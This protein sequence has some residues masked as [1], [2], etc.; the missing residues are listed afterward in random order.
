MSSVQLNA[1]MIYKVLKMTAMYQTFMIVFVP[2]FIARASGSQISPDGDDGE[3]AC[4]G[5]QRTLWGIIWSCMATIFACTWLAVHPNVPGRYVTTKGSISCFIENAKTMVLAVFAPEMIVGWAAG[6]FTMAWKLHRGRYKTITSVID[7]A[8]EQEVQIKL[9]LA[10]GFLVCMGG[11]Y[12]TRKYEIPD[13]ALDANEAVSTPRLSSPPSS[14]HDIPSD[15]TSPSISKFIPDST[16]PWETLDLPGT[17]VTIDVLESEPDLVKKLAAIDP[18]TI[19]DRSKGDTLSKTIS[20]LQLSWF[21]VQCVARTNQHL[22]ITLLEMSALSFAGLSMITYSLWWYKPL[23]VKY[24]ISLDEVDVAPT[25]RTYNSKEFL[26]LVMPF[27]H[28]ECTLQDECY[29]NILDGVCGGHSGTQI[30]SGVRLGTTYGVGLLFGAFHCLAWSFYFPSYVEMVLWRFS[31]IAVIIAVFMISYPLL[32]ATIC[33]SV[34]Q[35]WTPEREETKLFMFS[36]FR[37]GFGRVILLIL[38]FLELRALSPLAFC[39]VQWTTYIPH[40]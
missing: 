8:T 4:T 22:P 34:D 18:E 3:P 29:S 33:S 9:T 5:D 27:L 21:I 11:F 6:Q 32:I 38:A 31:S 28:K 13:Q 36:T 15:C 17:I 12:H 1:L 23:N 10:H 30:D 37:T 16:S 2:F 35:D 20:T 39:T 14:V 19:E 24:H 25:R 7:P 26:S 40:I